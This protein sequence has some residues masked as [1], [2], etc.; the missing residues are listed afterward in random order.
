MFMKC[1]MMWE[2][3]VCGGDNFN[4]DE[5]IWNAFVKACVRS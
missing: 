2:G 5:Y 3:C 4:E 1:I